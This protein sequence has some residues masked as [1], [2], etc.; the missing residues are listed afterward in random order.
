LDQDHAREA[1]KV[2]EVAE[3]YVMDNVLGAVK[4]GSARS[5]LLSYQSDGAPML[6]QER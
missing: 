3:A 5:A 6:A 2:C 1:A 4:S